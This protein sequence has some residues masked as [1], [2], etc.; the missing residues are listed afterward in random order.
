VLDERT[1]SAIV[2]VDV[3]IRV[4][5]ALAAVGGLRAQGLRLTGDLSGFSIR[6]AVGAR[7]SF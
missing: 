2:G 5:G 6:P 1:T 4:Y 3:A 7:V